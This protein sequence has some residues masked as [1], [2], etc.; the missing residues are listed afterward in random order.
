MLSG[1]NCA[2]FLTTRHITKLCFEMTETILLI[3]FL[4]IC[5]GLVTI[6]RCPNCKT[7]KSCFA[8]SA[9]KTVTHAN[10]GKIHCKICKHIWERPYMGPDGGGDG[11]GGF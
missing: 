9:L 5:Q 7:V 4:F 10:K 1:V 11:G 3:I 6:F 8:Q 2:T